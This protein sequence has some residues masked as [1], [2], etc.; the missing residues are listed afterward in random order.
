[1]LVVGGRRR[2]FH[3]CGLACLLFRMLVVGGRRRLFHLCG[4]A[5]LLFLVVVVRADDL[6][7]L[8]EFLLLFRSAALFLFRALRLL[9]LVLRAAVR[10]PLLG[11][12]LGVLCRV[13]F[14]PRLLGTPGL[15][16]LLAAALLAALRGVVV[17][18]LGAALALPAV[19]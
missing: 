11:D 4:L 15:L 13:L 5:C 16:P 9:A 18:L 2:L 7:V 17:V 19:L 10:R 8:P 6:P 14:R 12:L 1:M 3:L